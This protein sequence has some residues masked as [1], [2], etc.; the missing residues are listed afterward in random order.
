MASLARLAAAG[1]A[2]APE[3]MAPLGEVL[4][5]SGNTIKNVPPAQLRIMKLGDEAIRATKAFLP[6]GA[7]NQELDVIRTQGEAERRTTALHAM[8]G[9]YSVEDRSHIQNPADVSPHEQSLMEIKNGARLAISVGAG[10]C[11]EQA[12]VAMAALS[13]MPRD[14]PIHKVQFEFMDHAMLI[15]GH[16]D[17][18][19]SLVAIDPWPLHASSHSMRDGLAHGLPFK[20]LHTLA[21]DD[22]PLF[23][24]KQL[25]DFKRDAMSKQQIDEY[26]P[27]RPAGPELVQSLRNG[28]TLHHQPH[29]L[30]NPGVVYQARDDGGEL[31]TKR[32]EV[33]QSQQQTYMRAAELMQPQRPALMVA[34]EED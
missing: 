3:R 16:L 33:P 31:L 4:G 27:G 25:E 20:R 34:Q 19:R 32:H 5:L 26:N 23:S 6:Y 12:D 24:A 2:S 10:T 9:H 21:P 15:A 11:G 22:P 7:G 18:P 28:R 13:L 8:K 14:V 17:D 30:K 29:A 1:A